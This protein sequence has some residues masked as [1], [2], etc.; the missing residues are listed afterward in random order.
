L[1]LVDALGRVV[2]NSNR[3]LGSGLNRLEWNLPGLPSAVYLLKVK[4]P[5]SSATMRLVLE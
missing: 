3:T 4:T 2:A 1:L 5:G